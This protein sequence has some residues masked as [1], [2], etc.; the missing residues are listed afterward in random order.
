MSDKVDKRIVELDFNND[1]FKKGISDTLESMKKLN[2]AFELK[3]SVENVKQ[4][5]QAIK[6]V[7]VTNLS[8]GVEHVKAEFS[9]MGA[10]A[11]SA[12]QKITNAVMDMGA[13][14]IN[15]I[16][17]APITDGLDEYTL[18][19]DSIKTIQT[20]TRG[21][22]S[23]D[24]INS[25]L[26]KL[27][28]YADKTIYNFAQMTKYVGTFTASG[29]GL[30]ESTLA[31]Q[32]ISN[33]A[34]AAGSNAQQAS[35]AM[36]NLSQSLATGRL[37]AIDWK[38]VEMAG[39]GGQLFQNALIRTN[40]VMKARGEVEAS[41]MESIAEE[42]S[43]RDSLKTGWAT[44]DVIMKTLR[45]FTLERNE[46]NRALLEQEGYTE[47]LIEDIFA[48]A[49]AAQAAAT[50]VKT[51]QQLIGTT[52]EA[53]GSGWAQSWEYI[54]GDIEEAENFF[55]MVSEAINGVIGS[56]TDAR[57][58]LLKDWHDNGGR[59]AL[60]LTL[61]EFANIIQDLV[62]PITK[63][64]SAVF[65]PLS[66]KDLAEKTV[67]LLDLVTSIRQFF[68]ETDIGKGILEGVQKTFTV[69]FTII[70]TV[71]ITVL[72]VLGGA[73]KVLGGIISGIFLVVSNVVKFV[74]DSG[75]AE[76][77]SKLFNNISEF[78]NNVRTRVFDIVVGFFERLSEHASGLAEFLRPVGEFFTSTLNTIKDSITEFFSGID[79]NFPFEGA[80]DGL[81]NAIFPKAYADDGMEIDIPVTTSIFD[82][83][84]EK[85]PEVRDAVIEKAAKAIEFIS[86]GIM[87]IWNALKPVF[88]DVK[89]KVVSIW[90]I[91]KEA[92]SNSGIKFEDFIK[93]FKDLG[94]SLT[95]LFEN[96]IPSFEDFMN[97]FGNAK[98]NIGSF[99]E[100]VGPKFGDLLASMGKSVRDQL[101]GP[102]GNLVDF[103]ANLQNF[104]LGSLISGIPKAIGDALGGLAGMIRNPFEAFFPKANADDGSISQEQGEDGV[105]EFA[106]TQFDLV[107][108][109][110]KIANTLSN[111]VK[112]VRDFF[113]DVIPGALMGIGEGIGK[114]IDN[115][116]MEKIET[117]IGQVMSIGIGAV[118][119]MA[120]LNISNLIGK[121]S[122][123]ID[124]L[125]GMLKSVGTA[126]GKIGDAVAADFKA[127]VVLKY[128]GSI[129]AFIVA[130]TACLWVISRIPDPWPAVAILGVV[131][132]V[133]MAFTIVISKLKNMNLPAME[134]AGRV[135]AAMALMFLSL[136]IAI[137]MIASI[138]NLDRA[139]LV[140]AGVG[141]FV[142]A[143]M[144][145]M[146]LLGNY[147][148]AGYEGAAMILAMAVA[149]ELIGDV[150]KKLANMDPTQFING[151]ERMFLVLVAFTVPLALLAFLG[152]GVRSAGLGILALAAS[153]FVL[154][155]AIKTLQ[156]VDITGKQ[157]AALMGGLGILMLSLFA[158]NLLKIPE[159][160]W[161]VAGAMA[162]LSLSLIGLA[163][164]LRL[165][166][167]AFNGDIG[168]TAL[169]L[170]A[171]GGALVLL[172]VGLK[173][174]GG[175][176]AIK[177]AVGILIVV[178]ALLL[179]SAALIAMGTIPDGV[180]IKAGLILLS[181]AA[182][183]VVLGVALF[184]LQPAIATIATVL[185]GLGVALMLIA[186]SFALFVGTLLAAAYMA[187]GAVQSI[188]DAF[189]LFHDQMQGREEEFVQF[190]YT[191]GRSLGAI[192]I[193]F[194]SE[195]GNALSQIDWGPIVGSIFG[196]LF[197]AIG[198]LIPGI[199]EFIIN[200]FKSIADWV[201]NAVAG[202][203]GDATRAGCSAINPELQDA[204]DNQDWANVVDTSA[205]NYSKEVASS[206]ESGS[207]EIKDATVG[208]MEEAGAAGGEAG[209]EKVQESFSLDEQKTA[210]GL[211]NYE[212]FSG[213]VGDNVVGAVT[214]NPEIN[215]AMSECGID[216]GSLLPQ[217]LQQGVSE[218]PTDPSQLLS[219]M[220]LS[221]DSYKDILGGTGMDMGSMLK[222][223]LTTSLS[224]TSNVET[225]VQAQVDALGGQSDKY[226]NVGRQNAQAYNSGFKE[227]VEGQ[228]IDEIV[229]ANSTALSSGI[230]AASEV[231]RQSGS[232][233]G[234]GQIE[235]MS[236]MGTLFS[237]AVKNNMYNAA[238]QADAPGAG[239]LAGSRFG[240]GN[241]LGIESKTDRTVFA[242]ANALQKAASDSDP[243]GKGYQAGGWFAGGAST[244]VEMNIGG[245]SN[246]VGTAFQNAASDSDPGG[247]GYQA[248]EWFARGMASGISVY[249]SVVA[250]EAANMVKAAKE[251]ADKEADSHSPSEE[252]KKR[253]RW[254]DEGMAIGIREYSK[255]V[256][257]AAGDMTGDAMDNASTAFSL[258]GDLVDRVDWSTDPKITPILDLDKFREDAASMTSFMPD[259]QVVSAAYAGSIDTVKGYA[260]DMSNTSQSDVQNGNSF[261]ITL[262]WKAGTS[263]NQMVKQLA[264]EL[265]TFNLTKGR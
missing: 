213:V 246:T 67:G 121:T 71:G 240:E 185:T 208:A 55:T 135:F 9:V 29:V 103:F 89:N 200:G 226:T 92:V 85:A 14:I 41:A 220:G 21:V 47:D 146:T 82:D 18:K 154:S 225:D 133:I 112:A 236:S 248:G 245:M 165:L 209:A 264:D 212:E 184:Y 189:N 4:L 158:M 243:G 86:N 136:G 155:A 77:I 162:L 114:A 69:F 16:T 228:S 74:Q 35:N 137:N 127:N 115:M 244:G 194:F 170:V 119:L 75:I 180:L 7:D 5:D 76:T 124:S 122:V 110:Q 183:C 199:G 144:L 106:D 63:A 224:D 206:V 192:V 171:L 129:V 109:L 64:F 33:V 94:D 255:R 31:I 12:I 157:L 239:N 1:A 201:G 261:Y 42:G 50:K 178:G 198:A 44:N 125:A 168:A 204:M 120:G 36:Y 17:F 70:K 234:A 134:S 52:Q 163:V 149:L 166:T 72:N 118:S 96:G 131:T 141:G 73:F 38:S 207:D 241:V 39:M 218:N 128:V 84:K 105:Q 145:V 250:E 247:K 176:D 196:G 28:D 181:L 43:F 25:E 222:G 10:V 3:G 182:A 195:I 203:F 197:G 147:S 11:F 88:D 263:A 173:F 259:S 58:D 150:I 152:P 143:L 174:A 111:P 221:S 254:F 54:I 179:L 104:N 13:Q 99:V 123:L 62:E 102:L 232:A 237:M 151:L 242:V 211:M 160:I 32:G 132:L 61:V 148:K 257:S 60:I 202:L 108:S 253:G 188:I 159:T 48:E 81:K 217:G 27:N 79:F 161:K 262:D 235:A 23:L 126:V 34:A 230:E 22:N 97:F 45:N 256:S 169:A 2:S 59:D 68:E 49:E 210:D 6:S 20:N 116:P 252:M 139:G 26:G 101:D 238:D 249:T 117:F 216:M 227:Q 251:A 19:M 90:E 15:G 153:F 113:S 187:P 91:V 53:L 107:K 205:S 223:G 265:Q 83:I 24:E 142:L 80:F 66:G 193:G 57:N 100:N 78:T 186:G 40:E 93:L 177:G 51:F 172:G 130:F 95:K 87:N 167:T 98:D 214:D 219:S 37:Q 138:Q 140:L 260:A 56:M 191:L 190:G 229:V 164:A 8:S 30:K 46:E 175:P 233:Y 156:D 65:Q 258:M 215:K 231:G